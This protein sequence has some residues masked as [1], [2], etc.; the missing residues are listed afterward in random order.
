[1]NKTMLQQSTAKTF[2]SYSIPCI[3]SMFLTSFITIV[4]GL[5]IG[6]KLGPDGLAAINLTLP[7]LYILLALTVL[8]GVGG[9]TL[10]SQSLGEKIKSQANHYFIFTIVITGVIILVVS[11]MLLFFL[12]PIIRMLHAQGVI[13]YYAREFLG[14]MGFFYLFMMLNMIF[15]MFIRSEGKPQLSLF[16]GIAGNLINIFLDYLFIFRFDLGMHGAALASGLS[17]LIPWGCGVYYFC[18]RH[19]VYRFTRFRFYW[20]DLVNVF[21]NGSAEFVAQISG[22]IMIYVLNWIILKRIGAIGVAAMTIV[23]YV[24]FIQ[25]MVLTGIAIGIHPVISY[26]YGARDY[27]RILDMLS[28][29]LKAV[30]VIGIVFCLSSWLIPDVIVNLFSG[31]NA[32]LLK[33]A[34]D[35]LRLFSFAFILNGYSIIV[36]AYFTSLGNARTAALISILRNLV[37]INFSILFLPVALGNPGIWLAGPVTEALTFAVSATCIIHS[38]RKLLL[39]LSEKTYRDKAS[40]VND[41]LCEM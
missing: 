16:F 9:I 4:D 33:L 26:H 38:K 22:A 31:N 21:A 30:V 20:Q 6:R 7:V 23:G 40:V 17:V 34:S 27:R 10:A 14:T 2:F 15:S 19:S 41:I 36:T 11:L 12:E 3:I 8:T 28:V 29:S 35:G 18:S 39:Y 13:F 24:S 1:M 5:F 37:L 25:N 32:A